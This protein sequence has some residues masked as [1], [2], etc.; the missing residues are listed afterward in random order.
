MP[1]TSASEAMSLPGAAGK[2]AGGGIAPAR[3]G[4]P[5]GS[6]ARG[7]CGICAAPAVA[8]AISATAQS[9]RQ[10]RRMAARHGGRDRTAGGYDIITG[11][12]DGLQ[13]IAICNTRASTCAPARRRVERRAVPNV[14]GFPT[15]FTAGCPESRQ[16]KRRG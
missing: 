7:A 3:G 9:P 6:S 8:T 10:A 4:A 5:G 15:S 12:G 16:S 1:D 14:S 13:S 2:G 11:F